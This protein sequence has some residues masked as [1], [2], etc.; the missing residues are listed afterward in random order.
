MKKQKTKT[1]AGKIADVKR[2]TKRSQRLKKSRAKIAGAKK[3]IMARRLKG[4]LKYEEFMKKMMDARMKGE[5]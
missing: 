2:G 5:F 1:K 3:D 4:K